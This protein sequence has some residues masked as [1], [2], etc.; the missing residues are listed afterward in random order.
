LS[1]V[2][3]LAAQ[4]PSQSTWQLALQ[5]NFPG[6]AIHSPVQPAMHE[7]E[8]STLGRCVQEA[9]QAAAS[10]ALQVTLTVT[11][12]HMVSHCA[13][14]GMTTHS[15][16]ARTSISPHAARSARAVDPL[17]DAIAAVT[18]IDPSSIEAFM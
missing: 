5:S 15:A 13:L 18:N 8:Q 3:Q 9:S 6:S 1:R 17:I 14:G 16:R 12:V 7:P 4:R 11:G 10:L 2:L